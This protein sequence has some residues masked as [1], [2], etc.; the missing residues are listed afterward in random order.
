MLGVSRMRGG[1]G[2]LICEV[3]FEQHRVTESQETVKARGET[4]DPILHNLTIIGWALY[5]SGVFIT[6]ISHTRR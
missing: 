6:R 4:D 3:L 5:E 1:E 2:S